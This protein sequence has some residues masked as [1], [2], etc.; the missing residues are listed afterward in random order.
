M[1]PFI[2]TEQLPLK[3]ASDALYKQ[4]VNYFKS[5][6]PKEGAAFLS[7]AELVRI[8]GISRMT[9]RKALKQLAEEGWIERRHGVGT[10][11]GPLPGRIRSEWEAAKEKSESETVRVAVL[12]RA[13]GRQ[14]SDEWV[15]REILEGLDSVSLEN[16][17]CVEIIS[18]RH[19]EKIDQRLMQSRPDV[20][21]LVTPGTNRMMVVPAVQKLGIH[22]LI[23]GCHIRDVDIPCIYEDNVSGA[24]LAV[25]RLLKTGH[26][27]IGMIQNYSRFSWSFERVMGVERSLME[28]SEEFDRNLIF[29]AGPDGTGGSVRDFLRKQ[30]PD[31][32]I[33][34]CYYSLKFLMEGIQEAELRVPEDLSVITWDQVPWTAKYSERKFETIRLPLLEEGRQVAKCVRK[35]IQGNSILDSALSCSLEEGETVLCRK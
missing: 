28:R 35:L 2:L 25:E 1:K 33:A 34:G 6:Q 12:G 32:M 26:K 11:I 13:W 29:W 21:V 18:D 7:D 23:V 9:V 10:F 27:R 8:S 30:R 19:L 16:R 5:E 14:V 4:L 22:C 31:A 17:I 24:S 20:L 15:T 3:K